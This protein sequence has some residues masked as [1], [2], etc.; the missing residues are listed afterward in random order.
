MLIEAFPHPRLS[1]IFVTKDGEIF[2]RLSASV[3]S[4]GYRTV[5]VM[6]NKTVRRHTLMLET[7]KGQSEGRLTRHLD[8]NPENDSLENLEWGSHKENAADAI[9]HGTTTKGAKNARAKITEAD[10]IEIRRRLAVGESISYIAKEFAVSPACIHDIR[11]K[12]T[13]GWL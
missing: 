3:S 13:W 8:G 4:G 2:R 1:D 9:A 5:K 11:G 6:K 10:V 7:F 12:R